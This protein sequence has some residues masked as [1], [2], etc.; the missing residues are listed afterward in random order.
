[1]LSSYFFKKINNFSILII[2]N[3]SIKYNIGVEFGFKN[4]KINMETSLLTFEDDVDSDTV[5]YV[6]NNIGYKI[7]KVDKKIDF[8]DEELL[9]LEDEIRNQN[10]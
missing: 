5:I 1:M 8:T 7:E 9:L 6:V 2:Y 4:F 10:F 3:K